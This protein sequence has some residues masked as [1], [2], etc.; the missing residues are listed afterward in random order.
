MAVVLDAVPSTGVGPS[1]N[2][3]NHVPSNHALQVSMGGT[4]IA[5][6]VVVDLEGSLDDVTF[7]QLARFTLDAGEIAAG[8]AL[9]HVADKPVCFIRANLISLVGGT[10][11]TITA[12]Y[13][14]ERKPT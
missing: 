6:G 11:P 13:V 5:T 9:F 3:S 14:G 2:V 4:V 10:A 1:V 12:D 8:G 7:F